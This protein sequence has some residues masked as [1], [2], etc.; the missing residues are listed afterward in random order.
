MTA[1]LTTSRKNTTEKEKVD[2]DSFIRK[3][4]KDDSKIVEGRFLCFEP[5]GGSVSFPFRKYK[6]DSTKEYSFKDGETYKIPAGVARHLNGI[7]ITSKKINGT[8]NSCAY[9]THNYE[10]DSAGKVSIQ[11]GKWN[12]RYAFQT[13]DG[14]T[15]G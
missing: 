1:D 5:R 15:L 8:T 11:V 3:C 14:T 7:D 9:V 2:T 6:W 4:W 10:Q 12:R 13:M